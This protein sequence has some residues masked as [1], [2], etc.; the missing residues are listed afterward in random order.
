M[1]EN[2]GIV[3]DSVLGTKLNDERTHALLG[4]K[5]GGDELVLA[6]AEAQLW[7]LLTALIDATAAFPLAKG[8]TERRV[9]ALSPEWC[10]FSK[11][12]GTGDYAMSFSL[13]GGAHLSFQMG[14][15]MTQRLL[16]SIQQQLSGS[17]NPKPEKPAR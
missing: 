2:H 10:E 17:K 13:P 6:M 15:H 14:R 12:V 11:V 5:T 9:P 1:T 7:E 16:E 4:L 3:I 8:M